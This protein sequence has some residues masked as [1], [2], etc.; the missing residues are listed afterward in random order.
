MRSNS[1]WSVDFHSPLYPEYRYESTHHIDL[2]QDLIARGVAVSYV[3]HRYLPMACLEVGL[4]DENSKDVPLEYKNWP[5]SVE[6]VSPAK[7]AVGTA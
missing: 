7:N 2:F 4:L 6:F 1:H 3:T 5:V